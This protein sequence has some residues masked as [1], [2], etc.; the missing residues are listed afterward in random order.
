MHGFIT[1]PASGEY[2]TENR[3]NVASITGK[4]E[5]KIHGNIDE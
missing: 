1:T 2:V 5:N 3:R 4:S